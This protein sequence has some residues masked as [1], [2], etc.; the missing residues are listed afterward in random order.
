MALNTVTTADNLRYPAGSSTFPGVFP[1]GL[2]DMM[3]SVGAL[4]KSSKWLRG[5]LTDTDNTNTIT[6]SGVFQV[7]SAT[8]A[9]TLG[10]PTASMGFL[11]S[12]YTNSSYARQVWY[13]Q[14]VDEIWERFM[15]SAVWGAWK[16]RTGGGTVGAETAY[17]LANMLLVQDY[18]RRRGPVTTGGLGAVALRFDHG[19]ANFNTKIRPLLEARNLP[20][21]LALNSRSWDLAEN[22]GVTAS[23]VDTW[24][25]GGLAEVWNHGAHHG[26]AANRAALEDAIITGL[27]ELRAQIPSAKI[28]GFAVPGVGGTNYDGFNGGTT[29]ADFYGT[30][31]GRLILA[32]HA[33]SSGYISGTSHR[34]LDGTVR[35]G[36]NH[37][38]IDAASGTAAEYQIDQ[39]TTNKTGLQIMLHP[40]V[41]DTADK[42]TTAK[43]TAIFDHIAAKRDAGSLAVLSP[44]Q[45]TLA[46]A[47]TSGG[48]STTVTADPDVAGAYLIS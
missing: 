19:L 29:V 20:Y 11:E 42:V 47:R 8:T 9:N 23:M 10:L 15:N 26:D 48:T 27:S 13:P 5:T 45:L 31:A 21:S 1:L 34:P 44:Y 30:T 3:D 46:D 2:K 25:A 12:L 35:Q 40:S 36:M 38:T 32:N 41:V 43:L 18:T 37:Y 4:V 39:A 16:K 33:V 6:T 28:D 7:L 24:V 22:T 14:G 17:G